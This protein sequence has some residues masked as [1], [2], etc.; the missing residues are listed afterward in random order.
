M[1][2][3]FGLTLFLHMIAAGVVIGRGDKPLTPALAVKTLVYFAVIYFALG[4][5]LAGG[6]EFFKPVLK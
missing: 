4:L 3:L 6:S 2:S 1:Q 5:F